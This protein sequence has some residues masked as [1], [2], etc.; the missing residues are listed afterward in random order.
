[1]NYFLVQ[2]NITEVDRKLII[3]WMVH[4]IDSFDLSQYTLHLSII[5]L[6]KYLSVQLI[7]AKNFKA[8]AV[9]CIV[10]ASKIEEQ[11]SIGIGA[12]IN[13][14][15]N[16]YSTDE[17]INMELDILNKLNYNMYH[18]TI[19]NHIDIIQVQKNID[20]SDCELCYLMAII[21]LTT[22]DYMFVEP[23]LMAKKIIE[24][25]LLLGKYKTNI[26]TLSRGSSSQAIDKLTLSE[27][28]HK[29]QNMI[30]SDCLFAYLFFHLQKIFIDP[31][32]ILTDIINSCSVEY[33]ELE[34][35]H[36]NFHSDISCED[37][38]IL[39]VRNKY[40]LNDNYNDPTDLDLRLKKNIFTKESIKESN[41]I[42]KLGEGTF[43]KVDKV[44]LDGQVIA[45]KKIRDKLYEQG[46][47]E[48][49]LRE[50]NSLCILNHDSITKMIGFYYDPMDEK[51][52][53]GLE[54][55][56]CTL[57]LYYYRKPIYKSVKIRF[58]LQLL[59]GLE[60]MHSKNIMHRDISITNI[61][62]SCDDQLKI[63]DLGSS[64]Y[65]HH[66]YFCP[67]FSTL[68]CALDYRAIEILLGEVPYSSKIDV[69]SCACVIVFMLIERKL[70]I[71]NDEKEIID[72]IFRVFGTPHDN[73]NKNVC[74]WPLFEAS[75]HHEGYGLLRIEDEYPK[76][77]SIL[78]KMFEYEP[79]NRITMAKA[80]RL[81][82]KSFQ[83]K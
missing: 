64:R 53:I 42:C 33:L 3:K 80:L 14:C 17:L 49:F 37:N 10:L 5:L 23:Q 34:K 63:S 16:M 30:D 70:F 78:Y 46:I 29:L 81:F 20:D 8:V 38:Y 11:E 48:N 7:E 9:T 1:M 65:F 56:D 32:K 51:M 28:V 15:D 62:I 83:V 12:V 22:I 58:I 25:G 36:Y 60:Y 72:K 61:L 31:D 40:H 27:S 75:D 47:D 24:F 18:Q 52:L 54:L 55:M 77:V 59:R 66:E 76:Q 50:I 39:A 82:D 6:D 21:I 69:W 74:S 73:F 68:V 19:C 79:D 13:I 41:I 2:P 71:S 45:L 57:E 67:D 26:S 4:I 44:V 43:G 35:Y